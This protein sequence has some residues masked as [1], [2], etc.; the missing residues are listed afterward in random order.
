MLHRVT[1]MLHKTVL[2]YH[3]PFTIYNLAVR[4]GIQN[5]GKTLGNKGS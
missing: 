1:Q 2:T 3:L 5:L 4:R